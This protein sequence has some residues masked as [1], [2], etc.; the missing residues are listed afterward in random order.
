M[1]NK[2]PMNTELANTESLPLEE[3]QGQVPMSL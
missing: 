1:F 3:I 2:I